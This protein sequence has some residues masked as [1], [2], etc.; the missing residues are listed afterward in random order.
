MTLASR[1]SLNQQAKAWSNDNLATMLRLTGLPTAPTKAGMIQ[2][3]ETGLMQPYMLTSSDR[4]PTRILSIDLGIRNL[5][6]CVLEIGN[7]DRIQTRPLSGGR[8]LDPTRVHHSDSPLKSVF[9]HVRLIEWKRISLINRILDA[10]K[11]LPAPQQRGKVVDGLALGT[12]AFTPAVLSRMT[13]N[14][15][16]EAFIPMNV[17]HILIERQRHRSGGAAPIQEWTVRVNM[18]ESMLHAVL[19]TFRGQH[20]AVENSTSSDMSTPSLAG[21]CTAPFVHSVAPK[22]VA[23]FWCGPMAGREETSQ[24][25]T[26]ESVRGLTTKI[27]KTTKIQKVEVWLSCPRDQAHETLSGTH[28]RSVSNNIDGLLHCSGQASAMRET[29]LSSRAGLGKTPKRR[30]SIG[31]SIKKTR[32]PTIPSADGAN[33]PVIVGSEGT[34]DNDVSRIEGGKL[35]DLA[36]CLLQGTAWVQWELN[37]IVLAQE[38]LTGKHR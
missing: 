35:D 36:D 32:S 12:S 21:V 24:P 38:L 14:L 31:T 18:F 9:D 1:C 15:V 10:Q 7:I 22:N 33:V 2:T 37:K 6:F 23:Q 13:Y 29:F 28:S 16:R 11:S 8:V 30:S 3:L 20:V 27:S 34:G 26:K 4:R 17:S 5:A 25:K 19:E